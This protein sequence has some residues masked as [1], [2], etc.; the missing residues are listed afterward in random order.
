MPLSYRYMPQTTC[1]RQRATLTPAAILCR[2]IERAMMRLIFH[3]ERWLVMPCFFDVLFQGD[4][5]TTL[6]SHEVFFLMSTRI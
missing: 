4:E 5:Y 1:A 2:L 6:S 3:A